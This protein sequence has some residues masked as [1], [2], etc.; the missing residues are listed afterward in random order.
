[1]LRGT[2]T[3][4]M[5]LRDFPFD[6]NTITIQCNSMCLM[7]HLLPSYPT[8]NLWCQCVHWRR[9]QKRWNLRY[10]ISCSS[11]CLLYCWHGSQCHDEMKRDAGGGGGGHNNQRESHC[12]MDLLCPSSGKQENVTLLKDDVVG[13]EM[14]I[15]PV[16]WV[17]GVPFCR[18]DLVQNRQGNSKYLSWTLDFSF[19][20]TF[21]KTDRMTFILR[22]G[23]RRQRQRHQCSS[24]RS[25]WRDAINSTFLVFF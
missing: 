1:M 22:I 25:Q 4:Y 13:Y 6:S 7:T 21:V 19:C 20:V 12:Y 18:A 17:V 3:N 24:S 15:G 2:I 11:W 16:D 5:D 9:P 14:A 23:L 10:S 8:A